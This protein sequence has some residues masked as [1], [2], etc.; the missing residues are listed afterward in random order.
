[1]DI[2]II[3]III[4]IITRTLGQVSVQVLRV[5]SVNVIPQLHHIH[6]CIIWGMDKG[7]VSGPLTQTVS[8]N[9]KTHTHTHKLITHAFSN[10]GILLAL[11]YQR[12]CQ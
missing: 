9:R 7:P 6:F 2:I 1:M 4:I 5:F 12:T 8:A 10:S 3:I 11:L